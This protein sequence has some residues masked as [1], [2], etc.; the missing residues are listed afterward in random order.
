V[1][2]GGRLSRVDMTDNDN[3]DV[4]LLN[5]HDVDVWLTVS[6]QNSYYK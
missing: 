1:A 6:K 3:V 2:G 5:T 4:S